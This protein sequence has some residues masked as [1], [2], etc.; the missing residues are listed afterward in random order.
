MSSAVSRSNTPMATKVTSGFFVARSFSSGASLLQCGHH[1]A[2]KIIIV[3]LPMMSA[4]V[5]TLPSFA[6]TLK[7][8][9]GVPGTG[10]A[11]A[12]GRWEAV[13]LLLGLRVATS[14][15]TKTA[16]R[17]MSPPEIAIGIHGGLFLIGF[18]TEP[19][20]ACGICLRCASG[21]PFPPDAV[22]LLRGD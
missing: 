6:V 3:G 15:T 20:R 5:R 8:V 12:A 2:K 1:E 19:R 14:T 16:A 7:S 17:A 22:A 9:A 21:R 4:F 10:E 18:V 11:T 13:W